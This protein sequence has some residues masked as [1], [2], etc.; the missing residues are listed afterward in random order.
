MLINCNM[1]HAPLYRVLISGVYA[2]YTR[3]S[4]VIWRRS[5][6]AEASCPRSPNRW[7]RLL[8]VF[9][10]IVLP[11]SDGS[12]IGG[13]RP[14]GP[15]RVVFIMFWMDPDEIVEATWSEFTQLYRDQ[16]KCVTVSEYDHEEK[17]VVYTKDTPSPTAGRIY[18]VQV[19]GEIVCDDADQQQ[20]VCNEQQQS[21]DYFP[22]PILTCYFIQTHKGI[23]STL[24]S[25]LKNSMSTAQYCTSIYQHQHLYLHLYVYL[26][27]H[28]HPH[29]V[30]ALTHSLFA[31][32]AAPAPHIHAISLALKRSLSARTFVHNTLLFAHS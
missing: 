25:P 22:Q 6:S 2:A 12:N 4:L 28:L 18:L 1:L 27:L 14:R 11:F 23:L 9:L 19:Q 13:W 24:P 30:L 21:K 29:I 8:Y 20:I 3:P 17:P 7:S 10:A 26:Y 5:V 32:P 15:L 31:L 16:H